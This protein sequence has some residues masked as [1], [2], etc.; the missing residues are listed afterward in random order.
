MPYQRIHE[1]I[2]VAGTYQHHTFTPKKFRWNQ[3][4]FAIDTITLT[5]N[6]KDGGVKKRLYSVSSGPNIY[7]LEFNRDTESWWLEE[8]WIDG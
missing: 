5:S 6:I 1:P 3:R 8:I 4:T 7:R 2:A